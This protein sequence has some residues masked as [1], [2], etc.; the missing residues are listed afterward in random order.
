MCVWGFISWSIKIRLRITSSFQVDLPGKKGMRWN[1][2]DAQKLNLTASAHR[3]EEIQGAEEHACCQATRGIPEMLARKTA[4]YNFDESVT[5]FP[6]SG[7]YLK[8]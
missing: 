5:V 2:E 7:D 3:K 1:Y 4:R 6:E 8:A